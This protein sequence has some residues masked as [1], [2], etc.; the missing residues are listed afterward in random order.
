M[1]S[2]VKWVRLGDYITPR[3]ERN[4]DLRYGVEL[5][6]GVNSDG[7]FQPTK[8]VTDGIDL[9]PYKAVWPG[10]IVYNPSRLNIGS[11][12]YRETGMCIV[13]HLYQVFH[14]KDQFKDVLYPEYLLIW[15]KRDEFSRIVD[16]YNYGSQR[17]EFNLKKLGELEIPLPSPE[18]Q[19]K[20]VNAWK[21]CREIK[22]QNEAKVAPLM[23]LCQSYIQELKHKTKSTYRIGKAIQIQD[24]TNTDNK[25][26]E[27][28]GLNRDK[29]FMPTVANLESVSLKKYK[30]V[31]KGQ[32]AFSGMQTGRDVCIR[33]SLY[34][35]DIPALISP[36]YTTFSLNGSEPLLP[37][38]MM[39]VFKNPEMDRLGWFYSDSS[40]RSNLDWNRFLDIEI[41]YVPLDV[42]RA[43][44]DI[45]K[46]A[47]E[48]KQIAAEAD[49]LSR[50]V[51][52][53]LLQHIIHN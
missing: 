22:E 49:R 16:Y 24:Q 42:Q 47:N 36:A 53:A 26:L 21:A 51:C 12:A 13:S 6:E 11:L 14:V 45:Y 15:F 17:A 28:L 30:V 37:E 50:E 48:A 32:F 3:N 20:V 9:K 27:V 5:I 34:D 39:L 43:I 23:Q 38:Y 29:E 41:P 40:V 2:K 44:V 7:E 35:K 33:I 1:G 4:S 31:T 19:Q 25:S 18:E 52:P 10:D 46:C 8:A